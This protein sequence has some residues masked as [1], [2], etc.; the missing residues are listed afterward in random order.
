MIGVKPSN[1]CLVE[2]CKD[3]IF[4]GTFYCKAH[5]FNNEEARFWINREWYKKHGW[6][7]IGE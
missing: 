4:C 2:K 7:T 5:Y 1:L 6:Y 3:K